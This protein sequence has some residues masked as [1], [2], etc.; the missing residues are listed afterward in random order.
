[1]AKGKS[2]NPADAFRKAQRK[3]ELKKNKAD[4]AKARDFAL[5]KKDTRDLEDDI[6][7][8]EAA[9]ELSASDKARLTELKSELEKITKKKEEYVQEHPEHRKLVFRSRRPTESR[10]EKTDESTAPKKRNLFKKNGLPRHPERSIYYDPVMN[11]YGVPPPGMPYVERALLPHE[12][13]SEAEEASVDDDIVMPEGPPPEGDS[14]DSDDDIPMP[15]GPPPPKPGAQQSTQFLVNWLLPLTSIEA[16]PPLPQFSPSHAPPL[17][18]A[19]FAPPLP[20]PGIPPLSV[21]TPFPPL[22]PPGIPMMSSSSGALPPPPPPPPGFPAMSSP[23][24]P[25]PGFSTMASPPPPP[26]GFPVMSS[27]PPPPP[28]GFPPPLGAPMPPP[29]GFPPFPP[30]H[31][32]PPMPAP[33]PGFYPRRGPNASV[34][35][36]PLSSIPHQTYQAHRAA[37][38]AQSHNPSLPPKPISGGVRL[39]PGG[40]PTA[41]AVISA[42]PELRDFKKEATAFVPAA[43]KR[44][45][46][47][48]AGSR[49]NAAPTVGTTD[50]EADDVEAAPAARPDLLTTLQGKIGAPPAKKPKVETKGQEQAKPKDDYDKFM[51]EMSDIL[52]PKA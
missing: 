14:E 5:V 26:P 28:P 9:S 11:P 42:E 6:S 17:P 2:A 38:A 37:R 29:A 35:Q 47:A 40:S 23:P 10:D 49:V 4:R 32:Q 19:A 43:L 52:G 39:G 41:S 46:P 30:T 18:G 27:F 33:P 12:V 31:M 3:K 36:D 22:P 45:K 20:P 25:P 48:G 51:E 15:E 13:D 1:M 8:L 16:P 44:K 7:K 24:L 34:V 21:G 50:G